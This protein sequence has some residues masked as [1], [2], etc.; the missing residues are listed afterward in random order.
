MSMKKCVMNIG[1]KAIRASIEDSDKN[2][3]LTTN[4]LLTAD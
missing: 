1:N 3:F 4:T 2:N